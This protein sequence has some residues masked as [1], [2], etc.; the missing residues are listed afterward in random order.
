MITSFVYVGTA[1]VSVLA[2][3]LVQGAKKSWHSK[4]GGH[5]GM[6]SEG[7]VNW[8]ISG[9][10]QN[11]YKCY[12]VIKGILLSKIPKQYSCKAHFKPVVKYN[13]R[14]WNLTEMKKSQNP[15]SRSEVFMKH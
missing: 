11:S 13:T 8:E 5:S 1:V 9:R 15:S 7:K 4:T 3:C 6:N 14:R 2:L 10:I 12:Q